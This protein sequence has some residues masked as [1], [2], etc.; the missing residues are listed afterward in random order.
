MYIDDVRE[1]VIS[2]IMVNGKGGFTK[3]C[4]ARHFS[5]QT[6]C[7]PYSCH[8]LKFL[9]TFCALLPTANSCSLLS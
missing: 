1:G 9:P 2:S 7:H 8:Q 3:S 6:L 4:K 5:F